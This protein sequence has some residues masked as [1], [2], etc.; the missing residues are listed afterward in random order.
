MHSSNKCESI[1]D[2]VGLAKAC[3]NQGGEHVFTPNGIVLEQ[4]KH[5]NM[6]APE[7]SIATVFLK[8]QVAGLCNKSY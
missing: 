2:I 5:V 8:P 4:V 7:L 6:F 3:L 1:T